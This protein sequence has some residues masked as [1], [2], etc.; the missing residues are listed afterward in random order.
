MLPLCQG[1]FCYS[2]HPTSKQAVVHYKLRGDTAETADPKWPKGYSRPQDMM[3]SIQS[4]E[5]EQ[6]QTYGV[7]V[8]VSPSHCCMWWSLTLLE[9]AGHLPARGKW[10]MNSLACFA[11]AYGFSFTSDTAVIST[12]ELSHSY[13]SDSL[14]HP[15][16]REGVIG[17]VGLSWG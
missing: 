1:L 10:R 3:L 16:L 13:P 6:G 17:C 15:T 14:L 7:R 4:W 8:F 9:L 11:G 2:H 5:E 12:H